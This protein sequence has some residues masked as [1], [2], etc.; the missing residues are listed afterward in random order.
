MDESYA[1]KQ[2]LEQLL[3]GAYNNLSNTSYESNDYAAATNEVDTLE[4]ELKQLN[5]LPAE[6]TGGLCESVQ[7]SIES[8]MQPSIESSMQPPIESSMTTANVTV[9]SPGPAFKLILVGDGGVG[10]TSFVRRHVTGE[11]ERK[12]IATMGVHVYPLS[13]FTNHGKLTFNVWDTSGQEKWGGLRDGY[14]MQGQCGIIMFDVTSRISYKNV[15]NWYQDITRVCGDIPI[16]LCGNKVDVPER[17]VIAKSITFHRKKHLPYYELSARSNYNLAQP[18]QWLAKKVLGNND[19]HFVQEPALMP[20]DVGFNAT[21]I[22]QTQFEATLAQAHAT[23]LPDDLP[24]G[25]KKAQ[26]EQVLQGALN[27]LSNT[28]HGSN[29]YAAA[30]TEVTQLESELKRINNIIDGSTNDLHFV[31][32]PALM[33]HGVGFNANHIPQT[34]FE[35]TLAQAH[36][37]PLPDDLPSGTKKAQ[38]EQVLQGA[39]NNLSNT[40]HG[41]NDYAAATTEVTQLESEL[42]RINNIIDGSTNDSINKF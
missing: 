22:T 19:L 14:Y 24:S 7:P 13:F 4:S 11:F 16:V 29:D 40:T 20:P 35:A 21:H 38:L 34:Q 42:K 30:T 31:Q 23:P 2:Q 8:S 37:T 17:T 26:L 12:Y 6:S 39:L 36:T 18:F 15:S 3:Q 25:T 5:N 28:T 33:P 10:K 9:Q 27:N 1:K 41:S 32:E